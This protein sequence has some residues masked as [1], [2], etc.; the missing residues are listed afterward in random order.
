MKHA[1]KEKKF[2][3]AVG[4]FLCLVIACVFT[5]I[6]FFQDD[7]FLIGGI[8]AVCAASFFVISFLTY[9]NPFYPVLAG[10]I[11]YASLLAILIYFFSDSLL[12][13]RSG[14]K[15]VSYLF[16]GLVLVGYAL[17]EAYK[18]WK[19]KPVNNKKAP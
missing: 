5:S 1:E 9:Y 17:A 3:V 7:D 15:V 4:I 11:M 12:G 16:F 2:G 19:K 10:M 13:D 18:E 6:I 8:F 14:R